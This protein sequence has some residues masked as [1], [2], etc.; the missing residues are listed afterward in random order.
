MNAMER[1]L[2]TNLNKQDLTL[3]SNIFGINYSKLEA[4]LKLL[5]SFP[6]FGI[7]KKKI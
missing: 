2:Q 7:G 6:E 4:E 5:K 3:L 1:L